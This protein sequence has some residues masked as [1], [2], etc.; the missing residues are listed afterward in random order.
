VEDDRDS[1]DT[2]DVELLAIGGNFFSGRAGGPSRPPLSIRLLLCGATAACDRR[3]LHFFLESNAR[4]AGR[5]VHPSGAT[6]M[7]C[8]H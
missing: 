3:L 2:T 7:P 1:W 5:R 8:R 4:L 6:E